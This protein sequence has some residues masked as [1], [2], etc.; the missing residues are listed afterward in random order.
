MIENV[1][2]PVIILG[3]GVHL[4]SAEK[5]SIQLIKKSGFPVVTT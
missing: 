1:S 4:S 5:A 2:R 3:W